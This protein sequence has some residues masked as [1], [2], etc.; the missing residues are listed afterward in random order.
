MM[1][2]MSEVY[3]VTIKYRLNYHH[4]L[5]TTNYLLNHQLIARIG[6]ISF[7]THGF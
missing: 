1:L 5:T 7:G 3:I 6:N 4:Q 2:L